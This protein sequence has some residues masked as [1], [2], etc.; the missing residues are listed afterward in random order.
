MK[1]ARVFIIVDCLPEMVSS[2]SILSSFSSSIP[3]VIAAAM[4][5]LLED[6]TSM[7]AVLSMTLSKALIFSMQVLPERQ[8]FWA[9]MNLFGLVLVED[10]V[11]AVMV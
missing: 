1:K 8:T 6:L 11:N 10:A 4:L 5:H 2:S 7:A 9:R 3:T